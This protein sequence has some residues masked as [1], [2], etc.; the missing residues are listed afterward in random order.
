MLKENFVPLTHSITVTEKCGLIDK[1]Y[2]NKT[3]LFFI[4]NNRTK[5]SNK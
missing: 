4:L 1:V 3:I 2:T 5:C